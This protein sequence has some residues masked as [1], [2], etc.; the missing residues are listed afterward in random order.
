MPPSRWFTPSLA[1]VDHT[2]RDFGSLVPE[3]KAYMSDLVPNVKVRRPLATTRQV[4]CPR[5][6]HS[7]VPLPPFH[8]RRSIWT[9]GSP[10]C[11]RAASCGSRTTLAPSARAR[12]CASARACCP[13]S[14]NSDPDPDP[15][16][17]PHQVFGLAWDVT[18]GVNID[19]DASA[20]MLSNN[21]GKLALV[22][23]VYFGKLASSDGS[24]RHCG[25]QRTGAAAGDD[26]QIVLNLPS[27]HP[28]VYAIG[29]VINSYSG[30][31]LLPLPD[32]IAHAQCTRQMLPRTAN[33]KGIELPGLPLFWPGAR[34]RGRLLVPPFRPVDRPGRGDVQADGRPLARQ[35]DGAADGKPAP[36][37]DHGRVSMVRVAVL[38]AP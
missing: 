32:A 29:I 38:V 15:N 35:E 33:A 1:Q 31:V 26:E 16:P 30:Q 27:V 28:S 37:P 36:R 2:A 25:D 10:S 5:S 14:A 13:R 23:L 17:D 18:D 8:L 21:G 11:A 34:R 6:P 19:L 20:I 9:S 7:D 3:I 24:I 12:W 22:D 4:V